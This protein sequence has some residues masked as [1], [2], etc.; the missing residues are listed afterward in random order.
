MTPV[1]EKLDR[2]QMIELVG[3]FQRGEVGEEETAEALE[4][5]RRSS[6]HPEVDGLIF[7]PPGGQELSAEEVVDRALGHRPIEL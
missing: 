2:D 7:Y 3:R 6:G 4:A 1:V 5:L